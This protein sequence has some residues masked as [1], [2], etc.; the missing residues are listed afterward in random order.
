MTNGG[1]SER[2]RI[3]SA[4]AGTSISPVA[5]FGFSVPAGRRRTALRT[6]TTSSL[7][8]VSASANTSACEGSK[9][10]CVIPQRSRTSMKMSPP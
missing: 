9:I 5:S 7:R 3:S 2:L 1:V 10:T 4:A 8:S 6:R